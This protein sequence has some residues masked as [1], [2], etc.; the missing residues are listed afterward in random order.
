MGIRNKDMLE[1]TNVIYF[2]NELEDEFSRAQITPKKIDK[3]Y[4]YL[5]G[6]GRRLGRLFFYHILAKPIA[7]L[8][9]KIKYGHRIVNRNVLKE[10]KKTGFFLYGNHTN[11][12]A[13]ALVPTMLSHPIG[14]YVIVHAN[15]VSMP[16]L[17]KITPSLGALPLPDDIVAAR[18]FNFAIETLIENKKCIAIY[19]EAH[20]W[21]YYTGIRNYG[22]NAFRY[23]AKANVPVF[24]F[25][26]TYHKKL[27]K[28]P[29]IITYI[30]GPFYPDESCS[31]GERRKKLHE[32]VILSMR[33]NAKKNTVELIKY[34]KKED[35]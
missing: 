25:T 7:F 14:V 1:K 18:N 20:I 33:N 16:V 13:D 21:P 8:Y 34:V 29:R 5:G 9:L 4:C 12:I 6:L 10:V 3:D 35:V 26:N 19:P 23:P 17:G 27:G 11:P 28:T 2:E 15:N 31:L 22:D 32:Q 30:D 24:S